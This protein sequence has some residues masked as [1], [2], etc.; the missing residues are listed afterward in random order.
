MSSG[1]AG[2]E[3][4]SICMAAYNGEKYIKKQ[5]ES[6]LSQIGDSDELIIVDD[7]SSDA[8]PDIIRS[9]ADPR[10][11]LTVNEK[12]LREIKTFEKA[13]SMATGK[14]IFLSDQDDV[15]TEGRYQLMLD[16]FAQKHVLCV[17]G[18]LEAI[19]ADGNR[20]ESDIEKL[21]KEDSC[22]Y[23]GN[24]RRIFTGRAF[25]YGCAMAFDRRLKDIILPFP[26]GIECHDL[27]IAMAANFL[28]SNVHLDDT[29]LLHRMHGRNVTDYDRPLSAKLKSRTIMLSMLSTIKKRSKALALRP[30]GQ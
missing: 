19:D 7:G 22:D 25:Y 21:R 18:N 6:I 29:V 30:E 14:Y 23:K 24:I 15:W 5:L 2:L 9:M 10:I 16:A 1:T 8:T 17:S 27:W 20:I 4:N 26:E 12:N 28:K 13:I 3:H 11:R